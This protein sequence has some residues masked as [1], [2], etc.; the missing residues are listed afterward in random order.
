[1]CAEPPE[2]KHVMTKIL[3]IGFGGTIAMVPSDGG[4]RPAKGVAELFQ[5][6]PRL[7][8]K[9]EFTF[10]E[11]LNIDSTNVNPTHWTMLA[12]MLAEKM[13]DFDAFIVTH[14]TDTMPYTSTAI[15]FAFG[16]GLQKP[17]LFTGSQLPLGD[18]G[19]DAR[20]NM[21]RVVTAAIMAVEQ[22]IAEVMIVFGDKVLR[23]NRTLKMHEAR[24]DAFGSPSF[25]EL[26]HITAVGLNF[27]PHALKARDAKKMKLRQHFSP[28]ITSMEIVPGTN[29]DVIRAIV[30]SGNCQGLL[31]K[32]LGA[33]NIPD[34]DGYSLI[35]VIEEAV[36]TYNIPVLIANKFVGGHVRMDIY[37]LGQKAVAVGVISAGDMT[38]VAAQV[39][40][41]WALSSTGNYDRDALLK[42]I[43]TPLAGEISTA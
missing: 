25:P 39:K 7:S 38:D 24:F 5:E 37:E 36:Q 32:S 15:S 17:I 43:S 22:K 14:G 1:M 30:S 29:P 27:M 8:D 10:L 42:T 26:G 19:T 41:M 4:L 35:P 13:D 18:F 11:M 21:E 6:V 12:N 33:G 20:V 16:A 34:L 40:L 31:L 9:G 23:A 28:A 3:I 2:R